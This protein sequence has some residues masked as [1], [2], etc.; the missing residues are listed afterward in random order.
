MRNFHVDIIKTIKV[1]AS[2]TSFQFTNLPGSSPS[3]SGRDPLAVESK[4]WVVGEG[5]D[6]VLL[7]R[8][9]LARAAVVVVVDDVV[10][11]VPDAGVVHHQVLVGSLHGAADVLAASRLAQARVV[12]SG[13]L[14]LLPMPLQP[15]VLLHQSENVGAL[16]LVVVVVVVAILPDALFQV[17]II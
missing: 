1:P 7:R 9:T 10:D 15:L 8:Q 17:G 11:L 14:L 12:G 5:G 6:L 2:H 13:G 4:Q 3:V 16:L